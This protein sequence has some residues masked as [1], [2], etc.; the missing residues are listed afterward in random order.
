MIL[1]D[2]T[3][4]GYSFSIQAESG[5]TL[6]QSVVFSNKEEAQS[7]I[8]GLT[9]IKGVQNTFERKTNH[10]GDFLFNLKSSNGKLIGQSEL[11]SSEAGLQNGINNLKIVLASL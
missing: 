11:Y 3:D 10:K 8:E 1:L 2:K 5:T 6:L 7:I 4:S 9:R